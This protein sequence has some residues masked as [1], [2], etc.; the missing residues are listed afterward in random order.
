MT[1]YRID[2]MTLVEVSNRKA[3]EGYE[4]WAKET[5]WFRKEFYK[6][7]LNEEFAAYQ[8]HLA[9]P[10]PTHLH[11][12]T[13]HREIMKVIENNFKPF[14]QKTEQITCPECKSV[15]EYTE[16]DI[17][18]SFTRIEGWTNSVQRYRGFKCPCCQYEIGIKDA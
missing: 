6:G 14:Q 10:T 2:G 9:S 3:L 11:T 17:N 12:F 4:A 18:H 7:F 13:K 8:N 5:G 15:L 1:T 16:A